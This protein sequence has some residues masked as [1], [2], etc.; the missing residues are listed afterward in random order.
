MTNKGGN[1]MNAIWILLWISSS[2]VI[3]D[4]QIHAIEWTD[5]YSIRGSSTAITE[6]KNVLKTNGKGFN[7]H[8]YKS[9]LWKKDN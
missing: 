4:G 2:P 3:H 7:F 9:E 6:W 1:K 5:R 8:I